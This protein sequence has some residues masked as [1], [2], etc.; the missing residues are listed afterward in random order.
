MLPTTMKLRK[1]PALFLAA[2]AAAIATQA[3]AVQPEV[4][5]VPW[6]A[7]NPLIPHDAFAGEAHTFK[8]TVSPTDAASVAN[9]EFSWDFGDGSATAF[10]AVTNAYVVEAS[11]TYAAGTATGTIFTAKL[12]VRDKNTGESDT[13][14]YFVTIQTKSLATEV[15]VAI[16]RG[17]WWLHKTMRRDSAGF[18]AGS[19]DWFY[20]S[21]TNP[22]AQFLAA[23]AANVQAFE[24]NGHLESGSA[25]NP[26]TETVAR[27]LK[28]VFHKLTTI[29]IGPQSPANPAL[30][31][32][33]PQN[34]DSNGNGY[35]VTVNEAD[36]YYQGGI[37]M[38]A[39]VASGTP[40]A[41]T[42]TG[43][44]PAGANPG[45]MGRTYADVLQDMHDAYAWAQYDGSFGGGWRY[46]A[47]EYTDN[48]TNQWAAIGMIAGERVFGLTTPN[49]VKVHNTTSLTN[50]QQA[51]G[52]FGYTSTS[53]IW[54]DTAT[55]PS[56]M[57]QLAW[58]GR[59]RG[60]LQWDRAESRIRTLFPDPGAGIDSSSEILDNYYGLFSF[61]KAMLLHDSDGD[62]HADP[63]TFL[64]DPANGGALS[65]IDWY[66]AEVSKGDAAD[67]VARTL[68]NDQ[69]PATGGWWDHAYNGA[70]FY[71]LSGFA[72][73]MLNRTVFASGVPVAVCDAVP[74]PSVA[75]QTINLSGAGSFHQDAGLSIVKWEWDLDDNGTYETPGV[76]AQVS[77]PA[78]GDYDVGLRVTD[79]ATPPN[80]GTTICVIQ[81]TTPPLAPTADAGGPYNFCP[82]VAWFL[83]GT[84][85][86]NPDDGQSEP[87]QPADSIKD[88]AWELDGDNDFNDATGPNPDV[89]AF[90][91][92]L[93]VGSYNIQLRVT[94]NTAT[95]FP[96]SGLPDLSDIDGGVV[97]VLEEGDPACQC[98]E[99]LTARPKDGKVQLV[100]SHTGATGYN[101]YRGTISGGPYLLIDSTASTYSTYLD[102]TVV[103]GNTYYYIVRSLS[104]GS[105][106]C[107]SNETSATPTNPDR[108]AR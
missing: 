8:G 22:A 102:S 1:Y 9:F 27:G 18:P 41:V 106:F 36:P 35:G 25:A 6:V 3:H 68:V 26:Y 70:K 83:D 44:A 100:W 48:S 103:N 85:S 17:L 61:T 62:G 42:S 67:G 92:A 14:N 73:V 24:V 80:T 7:N 69:N 34:P 77:F 108:R 81:V 2:A 90:F 74:N 30:T 10:A 98:V 58:Q 94:D 15:N 104:G 82:E 65:P 93:G 72:I 37:I 78:V 28:T 51:G 52:I 29:A 50:T 43:P 97:N 23:T 11:H 56:G 91:A 19:G 38:D 32:T 57:V 96:S 63:L 31:A 71:Y 107:Q 13:E 89:S 20:Y 33:N 84:S 12:T 86:I 87:G 88:Y 47:N 60:D 55:T 59:G 66:S 53:P 4:K 39:I 75:S 105:E 79:D 95:S 101:V 5:T 76:N 99:D 49:W 45:V 16:D 64:T 40:N 54:G 21:G 46:S